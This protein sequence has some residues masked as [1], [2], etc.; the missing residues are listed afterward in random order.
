MFSFGVLTNPF[1]FSEVMDIIGKSVQTDMSSQEL[2][3]Y[4]PV[5]QANASGGAREYILDNS[6]SSFLADGREDNQYVLLPRSG[7][8]D[9]LRAFIQSLISTK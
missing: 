4:L 6:P 9:Q 1:K 8:F 7:N 5:A 2:V 3:S